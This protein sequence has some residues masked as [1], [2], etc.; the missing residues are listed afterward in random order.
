[1]TR[2]MASGT[3]QTSYDLNNW[4]PLKSLSGCRAL[5]HVTEEVLTGAEQLSGLVGQ[6]RQNSTYLTAPLDVRQ[7]EG[8]VCCG[9]SIIV[10]TYVA[11]GFS[12][13]AAADATHP[14]CRCRPNSR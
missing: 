4:Y 1:M 11:G 2:R 5:S 13:N 8:D 14:A 7:E 10:H 12:G 9:V 6:V 3:R